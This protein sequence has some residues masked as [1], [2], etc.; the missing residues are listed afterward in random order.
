MPCLLRKPQGKAGQTADSFC[1]TD[2]ATTITYCSLQLLKALALTFGFNSIFHM[3]TLNTQSR[4]PPYFF[5]PY[6]L[7]TPF[8]KTHSQAPSPFTVQSVILSLTVRSIPP[9]PAH[10]PFNQRPLNFHLVHPLPPSPHLSRRETR[11]FQ[12]RRV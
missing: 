9:H 12:T 8:P 7:I 5:L 11:R 1:P 6:N 3:L 10:L 4:H 2:T